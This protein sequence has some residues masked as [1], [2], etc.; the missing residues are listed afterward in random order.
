MKQQREEPV[1]FLSDPR[2]SFG[3]F[4]HR[5]VP[6]QLMFQT[7]LHHI[8][9]TETSGHDRSFVAFTVEELQPHV[10]RIPPPT[11]RI[12]VTYF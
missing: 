11:P 5:V 12:P 7:I 6:E 1:K 3:M 8:L 2:S 4:E 10:F 9:L